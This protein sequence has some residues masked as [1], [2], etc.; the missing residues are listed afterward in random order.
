M[1]KL[2]LLLALLPGLVKAL[3]MDDDDTAAFALL[4]DSIQRLE[5]IQVEIAQNSGES[6]SLRND[7][8]LLL[9]TRAKTVEASSEILLS[10]FLQKRISPSDPLIEKKLVLVHSLLFK[11]KQVERTSD[12]GIFSS[13]KRDLDNFKKALLSPVYKAEQ[14]PKFK[15]QGKIPPLTPRE[16]PQ[17]QSPNS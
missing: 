7:L 1:K 10:Q 2:L 14:G 8:F 11:F 16:M 13:L 9:T 5:K 4:E 12:M 3:P 6:V 17:K 15:N